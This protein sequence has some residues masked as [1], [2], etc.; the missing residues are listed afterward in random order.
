MV[1]RYAG[2]I[3]PSTMAMFFGSNDR[4]NIAM[5]VDEN[6]L[7]CCSRG[8]YGD[9]TM[10]LSKRLSQLL[11]QIILGKRS[12]NSLSRGVMFFVT[13]VGILT[14]VG[15]RGWRN[16]LTHEQNHGGCKANARR[17]KVHTH[18]VS[19]HPKT[20]GGHHNFIFMNYH[21]K[22]TKKNTHIN[23]KQQFWELFNLPKMAVS[24]IPGD[25]APRSK[26]P[27][28]WGKF[29]RAPLRPP[30]QLRLCKWIL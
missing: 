30:T 17:K 26:L 14:A 29:H 20:E 7:R 3:S 9:P 1:G 21:P 2:T 28:P 25:S 24:G 18:K 19:S 4:K 11:Q 27:F 5:T 16:I 15:P 22:N 23:T 13:L 12:S 10:L 8:H 6:V